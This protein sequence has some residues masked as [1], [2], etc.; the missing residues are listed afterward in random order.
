MA[1][2]H[3]TEDNQITLFDFDQ[4][5]YGWRVF[6]IAKFLQ[7]SLSAGIKREIRDAF[8]AGYQQAQKTHRRRSIIVAG[9]NSNGSYLGMGNQH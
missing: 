4:C 7:V 5:G 6:D 3:F 1:N 2:V 9:S 8:L